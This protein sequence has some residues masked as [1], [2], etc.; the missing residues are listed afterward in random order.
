MVGR[1]VQRLCGA[2]LRAFVAEDALRPIFPPAGFLVDLHVHRA[3][4]QAL[5]AMDA[6][7]LVA[8][9]AQQR[10]IAHGLEKHRD[11]AKILAK[12]AVILAR[13]RPLPVQ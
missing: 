2:G 12:R 5:A 13:K 4:P 8:V 10:K 6:L 9:N 11:G 7:L 3:D 1:S